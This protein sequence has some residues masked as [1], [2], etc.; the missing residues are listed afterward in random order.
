MIV[1]DSPTPAR[2]VDHDGELIRPHGASL[3]VWLGTMTPKLLRELMRQGARGAVRVEP[4]GGEAHDVWIQRCW[5]DV[6]H[7]R[8]VV[9]L[10]ERG[11]PS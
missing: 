7:G 5:Y 6:E 1:P 4:S 11:A 2:L 8:M 10:K 3:L 9:H